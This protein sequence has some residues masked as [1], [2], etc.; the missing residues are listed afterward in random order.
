MANMRDMVRDNTKTK[1]EFTPKSE[2]GRCS[3]NGCPM[4]STAKVGG[5]DLCQYHHGHNMGMGGAT[6][7]AITESVKHHKGL[8]KK[9][10]YHVYTPSPD[11]NI[12]AM[13]GWDVLPM[14]DEEPPSLYL[15]RFNKWI[16]EQ[17]NETATE[18]LR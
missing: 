16:H 7:N 13:K 11:W 3:A 4:V 6:W 12:A 15:N 9:Y 5:V 10:V 18:M 1:K 2:W 14:G 17:I 8:I